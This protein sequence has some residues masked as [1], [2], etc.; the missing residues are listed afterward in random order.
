M[1][2]L[3][4]TRLTGKSKSYKPFLNIDLAWVLE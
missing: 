4:Y 2:R 1:T 3:L